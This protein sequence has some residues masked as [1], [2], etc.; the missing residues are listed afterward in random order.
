MT[1]GSQWIGI[2]P[3]LENIGLSAEEK[4]ARRGFI[5]GSDANILMSG[6]DTKIMRLWQEKRG[7]AESE[8]LSDVLQVQL[9]SWTEAFN[10]QW[11]TRQ[12]GHH[13]EEANRV[14]RCATHQFR[15]AS[16]D[17]YIPALN[18]I[19][20]GKHVSAFAKPDEVLAKYMP[21]LQHNM[22][23]RGASKA[24][25]SVIYGNH[26][27]EAVVID[28]DWMY[29][30]QL[31]EIETRFWSCVQS[32]EPPCHIPSLAPPVAAIRE[33]DMSQSN[34]WIAN[35]CD[36]LENCAAAK[37]F[38]SAAKELKALID[39]D[40]YR[41]FGGRIEAR[42]SKAGAITIRETKNGK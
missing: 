9:G 42:R 24:V 25:L 4:A 12:T 18:A 2:W 14:V 21:Q 41:A 29:Q 27:W 16:L 31:L 10:R 37:K 19:W 22:A 28:A 20:E 34:V 33:A 35:A 17:G 7:E 15:S 36:W 32:G 26:K 3:L 30:E 40:V 6:D 13:V 1:H 23:V 11:Y 8:D 5:G 38:D 39:P